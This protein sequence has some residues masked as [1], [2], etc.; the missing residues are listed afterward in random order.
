MRIG[1]VNQPVPAEKSFVD[2]L[3]SVISELG[4]SP[5]SAIELT[6][7]ATRIDQLGRRL[8][9]LDWRRGY[10]IGGCLTAAVSELNIQHVVP[11]EVLAEPRPR[12]LTLGEHL[13]DRI[14][15]R[16]RCSLPRSPDLDEGDEERVEEG[17]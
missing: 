17:E 16:T 4:T 7:T 14:P 2:S 1:P 8:H 13:H 12:S 5:H 3:N 6:R 11:A 15:R 9:G 10:E